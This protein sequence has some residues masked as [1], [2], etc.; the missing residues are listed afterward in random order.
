MKNILFV[1]LLFIN[2]G[3]ILAQ[4]G[5]WT[6]I[7][8]LSTTN[9]P[10]NLGI[11]G[12]PSA[13]NQPPSLYEA[14]EW[15]DI[16][17][18]FWLYGGYDGYG[19]RD[20]LWKYDPLVNIWVWISGSGTYGSTGYYGVQGV[21]SPT[22][23]PPGLGFGCA[24]WTDQSNNL[25]FYGGL[26][27]GP[28]YADLWRYN[29]STNEWTWMK[30]PGTFNG[31][32][33]VYGTRT[34]PDTANNPGSRYEAASAWTENNHLWFFG[35][36]K[37]DSVYLN[38][39]DLWRY[40]IST[41][42]WTWMKGSNIPNNPGH[43]ATIGIE[44]SVSVPSGRLSYSHWKD[45]AGN[46]WIFGGGTLNTGSTL[47]SHNDMWKYNLTSNNWTW[48][49]GSS[50]ANPTNQN[51]YGTKC[52]S[53]PLNWPRPRHENK[54][55]W[56]DIQG[57]FWMFGGMYGDYDGRN[58]LWKYC[59]ASNEWTWINGDS[60]MNANGVWGTQGVSGPNNIPSER[61]GAS[62]WISNNNELYLFGGTIGAFGNFWSD[63]WR[64]RIDTNCASCINNNLLPH[65][66]FVY[67]NSAFCEG[68]CVNFTNQSIGA[69]SYQW[70]F[71]GANP[72]TDTTVNPQNICYN[73]QGNYDITLVA[74]NS[75]G[76]DTVT[77]SNAILV[78][79]PVQFSP[80][81]QHVD[82]LFSVQGYTNY[83]WFLDTT[84]ITGATNYF[85]VVAQ[86]GNY[87]VQVTD[88]NGCSAV[89]TILGVEVSVNDL[90]NALSGL[91]V[92][93]SG[94]QIY[95]NL[96]SSKS[97][98]AHFIITDQL[99]KVCID[100]NEDLMAGKNF[101]YLGEFDLSSAIY[102]ISVVTKDNRIVKK[103]LIH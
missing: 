43:Y 15:K 3:N 2:S 35:G 88:S 67:S 78:Y 50:S 58:D 49:G 87:S 41:N 16:N 25:W 1:V 98:S 66:N 77:Y 23:A 97:E 34:I 74:I 92:V 81:S 102:F 4:V 46:F 76:S 100:R 63:L 54:A 82:T 26:S 64:F 71:P 7:N 6:W 20:E 31:P 18:N 96:N 103:I 52:I 19:F 101:I 85:L 45:A 93:T 39:N 8:G 62:A 51:T 33:P 12:V 32:P 13:S 99:G 48:I 10:A 37:T 53:S 83:Q 9:S 47:H 95:A 29:I 44:D 60:V 55:V 80:I 24:T 86:G 5:E 61:N 28:T 69:S 21:P 14:C 38:Y 90:Q 84:A 79:P 40:D 91:T 73:L 27:F 17:G 75:S 70:F 56:T 30:G 59:V 11:K 72:N 22:N 89:A 42:T 94:K 57:N 36:F 68:V 65:A